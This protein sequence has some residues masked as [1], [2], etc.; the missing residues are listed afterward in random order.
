MKD[1]LDY[2]NNRR[3]RRKLVALTPMEVHEALLTA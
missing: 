1:Y 3:Y 2:Y